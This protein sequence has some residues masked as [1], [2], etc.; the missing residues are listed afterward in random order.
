MDESF[1][2][3]CCSSS[4]EAFD[5]EDADDAS[6]ADDDDT[7]FVDAGCDAFAMVGMLFVVVRNFRG[8]ITCCK[9]S[10]FFN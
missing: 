8:R 10:F 2:C 5:D 1:G 9:I 7:P 3:C 6:D 4:E